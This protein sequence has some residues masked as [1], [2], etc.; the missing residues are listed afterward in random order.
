[1]KS[2]ADV[3]MNICLFSRY[4]SV[5]MNMCLFSRYFNG[6]PPSPIDT[7]H[8]VSVCARV[9]LLHHRYNNSN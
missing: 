8:D 1:M 9:M 5:L 6:G 4:F 7:G 2:L 3:L